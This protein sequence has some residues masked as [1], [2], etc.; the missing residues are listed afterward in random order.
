MQEILW[1]LSKTRN[2]AEQMQIEVYL[3]GGFVRDLF[4]GEQSKDIDLL[5]KGPCLE[6]GQQLAREVEGSFVSL[7]PEH[8][9]YRVVIKRLGIQM[10]ITRPVNGQFVKDL[11]HRD[12]TCNAIAL[13]VKDY[14]EDNTWWEK[15]VDPTR[16][17][18]DLARRQLR[19]IGGESFI[20]DPVRIVRGLRLASRF[21]LNLDC[22]YRQFACQAKERLK[23]VAGER[24]KQEL[25]LLLAQPRASRYLRFLDE[26]RV[27]DI[28]FPEIDFL[29]RTAQNYHHNENAWAHSLRTMETLETEGI[30]YLPED[31]RPKAEKYLAEQLT[32]AGSRRQLLKIVALFHDVG[33]ID[34]AAT[35]PD[36]RITFYNHDRAGVKYIEQYAARL[37][38]S[39]RERQSWTRVT[40]LHM[41]PLALFVRGDVSDKACYRLFADAGA[42]TGMLLMLAYAD[43]KATRT[44][45]GETVEEGFKEFLFDLWRQYFHFYDLKEAKLIT[46]ADLRD[47]LALEPG[48]LDEWL[49]RLD[50]IKKEE[51]KD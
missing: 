51:Q 39:K 5:V 48:P 49:A 24:L 8:D 33:K 9:I 10:D 15:A 31:I 12:F 13:D 43:V 28:I 40:V 7:S 17:L 6:F 46:G 11:F 44:A 1:V 50:E 47:K 26:W 4:L 29:R 22:Q 27:L 30:G 14:L 41:R 20:N 25:W 32:V 35:R 36:G 37:A 2:L 19:P 42:D 21:D 34:T 18:E 38:L 3:V 45:K 16:G 23:D